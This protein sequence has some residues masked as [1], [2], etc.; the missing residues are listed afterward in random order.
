MS[1]NNT[2]LGI[3][4][5]RTAGERPNTAAGLALLP[6]PETALPPPKSNTLSGIAL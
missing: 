1:A 3:E 2:S 4:A 5:I 6:I